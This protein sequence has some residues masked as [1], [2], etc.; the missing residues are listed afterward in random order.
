LTFLQMLSKCDAFAGICVPKSNLLL[1][2]NITGVASLLLPNRTLIVV[3]KIRLSYKNYAMKVLKNAPMFAFILLQ[4][5]MK[6]DENMQ[7]T[8]L[9]KPRIR[10]SFTIEDKIF[11]YLYY[12]MS[13]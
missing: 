6:N 10:V 13:V 5:M 9:N 12:F 4:N 2:Q 1:S 3:K 8:V 7:T 11:L